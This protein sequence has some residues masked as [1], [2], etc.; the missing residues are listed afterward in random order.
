MWRNLFSLNGLN[1]VSNNP[2]LDRFQ[3]CTFDLSKK[4]TQKM[5]CAKNRFF[6]DRFLA[7]TFLETFLWRIFWYPFAIFEEKSFHLLEGTRDSFWELKGQIC[8]K[9]LNILKN[10]FYTQ[11]LDFHR[12]FQI[13]CHTSKSW[14]ATCFPSIS[15]HIPILP[16]QGCNPFS[17]SNLKT[18]CQPPIFNMCTLSP[19]SRGLVT[20]FVSLAS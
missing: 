16:L 12:P 7:K 17:Q 14:N 1:G 15:T 11:V 18:L 13:L 9:P 19:S 8:K 6:W 20:V 3:K 4:Y 5:F 2:S 10:G